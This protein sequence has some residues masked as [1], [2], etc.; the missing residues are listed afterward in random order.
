MLHRQSAIARLL[1]EV[2]VKGHENISCV[3]VLDRWS[4]LGVKAPARYDTMNW[5][6]E[7][8]SKEKSKDEELR[9]L[10]LSIVDF[11]DANEVNGT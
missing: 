8:A 1:F 5:P 3:V 4:L 11:V 7:V 6:I 2:G 9:R 10:S